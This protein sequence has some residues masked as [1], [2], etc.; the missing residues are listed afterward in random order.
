[1]EVGS[2]QGGIDG[3][4]MAK[5]VMQQGGPNILIQTLQKSYEEALKNQTA[6]IT[7]KGI[8]VDKLV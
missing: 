6:Q 2:V 8:N 1:M 3:A 5:K 4:L 7:G